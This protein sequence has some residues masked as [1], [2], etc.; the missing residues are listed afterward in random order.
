MIQA[1]C[2]GWGPA[3]MSKALTSP[4]PSS[5]SASARFRRFARG[6]RSTA[7]ASRMSLKSPWV[8]DEPDRPFAIALNTGGGIDGEPPGRRGD[9]LHVRPGRPSRYLAARIAGNGGRVPGSS[10]MQRASTHRRS[11]IR[12][13]DQCRS[14]PTTSAKACTK[15]SRSHAGRLQKRQLIRCC[16]SSVPR[17]NVSGATSSGP[18]LSCWSRT[19][20]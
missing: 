1:V 9:P 6:D 7:C 10:P 20:S 13:G 12:A 17:P 19:A 16:T 8:D 4:R 18:P 3:G 15:A 14:N 5:R 2:R 11:P